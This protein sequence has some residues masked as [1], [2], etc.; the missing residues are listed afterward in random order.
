VTQHSDDGSSA[1]IVVGVDGSPSAREALRWAV[2]QAE[3]TGVAVEAVIAWHLP[4][5]VGGY[6]WPPVGVLEA[7]DFGK[8]AGEVLATSITEAVGSASPV[9]VIPVVAEGNPAQVLLDAA[10]GA[11]MLVV[12]SRGYGGFTEALLGSVS[13]HCVHHAQCPV[14]VI[15]GAAE[16]E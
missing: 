10:A 3:L 8:L 12:G 13:Q 5:M 16:P 2:R 1:R 11:D 6:A 4:L 7:T 15:R 14:V 9:P